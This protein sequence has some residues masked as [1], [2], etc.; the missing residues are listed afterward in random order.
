MQQICSDEFQYASA[1]SNCDYKI[2]LIRQIF[3]LPPIY[4]EQRIQIT[5]AS[6]LHGHSS[7]HGYKTKFNTNKVQKRPTNGSINNLLLQIKIPIL[8]E[9]KLFWH[10]SSIQNEWRTYWLWNVH[11]G[12]RLYFETKNVRNRTACTRN[13]QKTSSLSHECRIQIRML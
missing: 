7:R 13:E 6:Q 11:G 5:E 9:R 2:R 4:S 12:A 3:P 1:Q 8:W 10:R